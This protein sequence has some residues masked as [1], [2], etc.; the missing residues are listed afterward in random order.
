[1]S[2]PALFGL[3]WGWGHL[4]DV[5]LEQSIIVTICDA[6]HC[7]QVAV[8]DNTTVTTPVNEDI[9]QEQIFTSVACHIV[10]MFVSCQIS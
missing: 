1:M 6:Q 9:I 10:N 7:D 3:C 4:A 2:S 8:I 5:I